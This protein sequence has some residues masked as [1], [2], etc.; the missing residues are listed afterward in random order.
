MNKEK[1]LA[2]CKGFDFSIHD[3]GYGLSGHFEYEDGGCQGFGYITDEGFLLAFLQSVGVESLRKLEGKSC[4]VTHDHSNI[5][6]IEPLHK[7]D[8]KPFIIEKWRKW[9]EKKNSKGYSISNI[10]DL[11]HPANKRKII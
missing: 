7:K 1:S 2:R 11:T 5:Y 10:M 6:R 4:W 9:I 3:R 8:G